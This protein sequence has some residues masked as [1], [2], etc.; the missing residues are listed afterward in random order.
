MASK[1]TKVF[2]MS[3]P[4]PSALG[5]DSWT[6]NVSGKNL[7]KTKVGSTIDRVSALYDRKKGGLATGLDRP[8]LDENGVQLKDKDGNPLTLQQ[9]LEKKW[10]LEPGYLTNR[11]WRK[12]DSL[13][14]ED[15]TYFQKKY[16]QLNDGSTVLDMSAMEDELFYYVCQDSKFVANSEKEWRSH[17]WPYAKWYIAL[18]NESD[19]IKYKR[20]ERK[21]KAFAALHSEDMT[22]TMK[23]K[24][25]YLLELASTRISLTSQ[26]THNLLYD[27]ISSTT[28]T[29]GS[30]LDRFM[31]LFNK[32]S[33]AD[34]REE[35]EAEFLLKQAVDFRIL[36]EKQG[37]FIWVR[38]EGQLDLG[39]TKTE[40]IQ[41]ILNP[42]KQALIEELET[43]VEAKKY[44]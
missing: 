1:S 37:A 15:M 42:K 27:F 39:Q 4:R 41:F 23:N 29:P 32:L 7:K 13:R 28:F 25:V 16:W 36:H 34:G 12:G 21:S 43:L 31:V 24:F 10:G 14:E 17:Q 30:N 8:W 26:Q 33:T 22:D 44:S 35:L 3:I 18:E 20:N 9:K 11:P 5:I 38:P 40:A 19:E 2:I 6:S